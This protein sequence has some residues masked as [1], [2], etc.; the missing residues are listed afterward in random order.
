M[1]TPGGA[2]NLRLNVLAD[3]K[4]AFSFFKFCILG[5]Y[6]GI[7]AA[8]FVRQLRMTVPVWVGVEEVRMGAMLLRQ[9]IRLP[10][11]SEMVIG[12]P[13]PIR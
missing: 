12:L 5:N 11:Q 9:L 8:R 4:L 1:E 10:S 2:Q 6:T 13:Q 3:I 7:E